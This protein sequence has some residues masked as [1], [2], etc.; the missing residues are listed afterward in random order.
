[1]IGSNCL[2][3]EFACLESLDSRGLTIGDWNLFEVGCKI[4]CQT[5]GNGNCFEVR[6]A[7]PSNYIIESGCVIG[8]RVEMP[9]VESERIE[10]NCLIIGANHQKRI[11]EDNEKYNMEELKVKLDLL[12]DILSKTH[13]L[14]KP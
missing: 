1:V 6:S 2:I 4:Q 10:K 14:I 11:K 3:E 8:Q 7:V 5:I 9:P 13:K 12:K